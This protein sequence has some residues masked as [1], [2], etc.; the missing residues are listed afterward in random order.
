M[1]KIEASLRKN[2]NNYE[3]RNETY[4]YEIRNETYGYK[5]KPVKADGFNEI[6]EKEVKECVE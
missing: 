2:S 1:K 3:I 6:E 5:W 4:G